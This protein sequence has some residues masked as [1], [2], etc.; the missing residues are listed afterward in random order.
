MGLNAA[1][2]LLE[3]HS[4]K[5]LNDVEFLKKFGHVEVFFSTPFGDAKDGSQRLFLLKGPN[6]TGLNPVFTSQERIVEF[7]EAM[8]REGYAIMQAE[9]VSVLGTTQS[10]NEGD[11]PVKMGI[12]I[13]PGYYD[14]TIGADILGAV[15]GLI[16]Q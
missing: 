4:S 13:D 6:D 3:E 1:Q 5:K 8:E 9:F 2:E 12:I 10:V 11:I 7:Y 14:V 16:E 15:I